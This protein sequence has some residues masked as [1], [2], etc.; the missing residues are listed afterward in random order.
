T[1][2]LGGATLH[3]LQAYPSPRDLPNLLPS[4]SPH[5]VFLDTATD[6][7]QSIQLL[8]EV[9]RSG[10]HVQVIAILESNEPDF[11]LR[12]LRAGASD[13]L[14]LPLT[15]EQVDAA[16]GKLA[17]V[18]PAQDVSGGELAKTIAVMP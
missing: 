15:A 3:R 16:F 4:G 11:I 1:A 6:R 13:F 17:R 12:C 8:E 14:I 7:D 9:G 5:L 10:P 2:H 18:Q